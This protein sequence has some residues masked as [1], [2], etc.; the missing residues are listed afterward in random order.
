MIFAF[1]FPVI[2]CF[3]SIALMVRKIIAADWLCMTDWDSFRIELSR[4]DLVNDTLQLGRKGINTDSPRRP[5]RNKR[6]RS[7]YLTIYWNT[8][9]E[10]AEKLLMELGKNCVHVASVWPSESRWQISTDST[11]K[12]KTR[13]ILQNHFSICVCPIVID[14]GYSVV[15][16][17]QTYHKL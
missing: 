7:R 13:I 17:T 4:S 9:I 2:R 14:K 3:I 10:R 5:F 6:V 15:N 8:D 1:W 16:I 12:L 11:N